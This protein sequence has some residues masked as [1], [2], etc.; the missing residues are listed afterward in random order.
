MR[1]KVILARPAL[2][3]QHPAG[4]EGVGTEGVFQAATLRS[5]RPHAIHPASKK[6]LP[7]LGIDREHSCDND[8]LLLLLPRD[9]H[10]GNIIAPLVWR[11]LA[12]A[13]LG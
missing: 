3:E 10:A 8:H 12:S 9:H 6:R 7:L 11:E 5:R 4:I 2:E 1:V 13:L